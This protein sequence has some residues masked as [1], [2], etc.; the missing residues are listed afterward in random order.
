MI[1]RQKE[2][3]RERIQRDKDMA[4]LLQ[5]K[6]AEAERDRQKWASK[7]LETDTAENFEPEPVFDLSTS[8]GRNAEKAYRRKLLKK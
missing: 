8:E 6:Q 2:E 3:E 5:A 4:L 1:E 7:G